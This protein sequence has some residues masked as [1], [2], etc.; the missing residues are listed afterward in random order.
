MVM[1]SNEANPIYLERGDRRLHVVNR[2]HLKSRSDKS[3]PNYDPNY[4][5]NLHNWLTNQGGMEAVAN[6]LHRLP[7]S[8]ADKQEVIGGTAPSTPAK[9]AL[10]DQNLDPAESVFEELIHDAQQGLPP[11]DTCLATVGQIAEQIDIRLKRRPSPQQVS[12]WLLDMEHK[13]QGVGRLRK[14]PN[15]PN[16]CGTV[17]DSKGPSQRLW[18]LSA[19][20]PGGKDW[21]DF[22][23][24]E[25]LALWNGKPLPP[26]ASV[27]MF[28]AQAPDKI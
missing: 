3:S 16:R 11:F 21:G 26:R 6:Y 24:T 17:N 27:S 10:E 4:Y 12:A 25:L 15:S 18:H 14:D 9:T 8:A 22:S 19:K 20:G 7:L 28:P 13:G 2:R 1:F 5:K 23:P